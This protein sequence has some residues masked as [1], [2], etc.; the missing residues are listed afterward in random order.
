M[1]DNRVSLRQVNRE[2]LRAILD[3]RVAPEQERYV[4]S[5]AVSIAQAHFYPEEAWFR[6]IYAGSEPVGFAMLSLKTDKSEY[7]LWRFMID[8]RYQRRGYGR[9]ALE[10]L[11]EHVS[12]LPNATELETT[13]APGEQSHADRATLLCSANRHHK[14]RWANHANSAFSVTS[15]T[16]DGDATH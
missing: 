5:N 12:T 11:I 15:L 13:Y 2:N 4:T 7:F 6:A 16:P 3:L 10:L 14:N 9:R 1:S 8:R